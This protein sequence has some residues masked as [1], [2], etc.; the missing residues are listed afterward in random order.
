LIWSRS[1][2]ESGCE[3]R[4]RSGSILS[5]TTDIAAQRAVLRAALKNFKNIFSL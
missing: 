3:K 1:A 2:V 5:E 4:I